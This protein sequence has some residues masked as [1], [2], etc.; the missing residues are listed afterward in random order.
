MKK[1]ADAFK[2]NVNLGKL[3]L[4]GTETWVAKSLLT[5]GGIAKRASKQKLAIIVL[6]S[7]KGVFPTP[8]GDR[9]RVHL[10][11]PQHPVDRRGLELCLSES[12]IML[13]NKEEKVHG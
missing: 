2:R 3:K 1:K 4:G 8:G 12:G 10:E 13:I 7:L 5:C 9:I 11:I 6:E